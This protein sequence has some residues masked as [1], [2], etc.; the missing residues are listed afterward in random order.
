[1]LKKIKLKDINNI[2]YMK[3]MKRI[4]VIKN[5]ALSSKG[6]FLESPSLTDG[7]MF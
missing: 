2:I 4:D 1:M 7:A 3:I 5:A 6:D